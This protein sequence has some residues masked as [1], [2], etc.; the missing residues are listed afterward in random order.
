MN[1]TNDWEA[2]EKRMESMKRHPSNQSEPTIKVELGENGDVQFTVPKVIMDR[3]T[4]EVVYTTFRDIDT[5]DTIYQF[6]MHLDERSD[7]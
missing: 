3:S 1:D 4:P 5:D 6:S 7:Q 2:D